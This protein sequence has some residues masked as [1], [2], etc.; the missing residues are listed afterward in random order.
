MR[1][2]LNLDE[3]TKLGINKCK[4]EFIKRNLAGD[5]VDMT[6]AFINNPTKNSF[7]N[8]CFEIACEAGHINTVK[9]MLQHPT[10]HNDIDNNNLYYAGKSGN[11]EIISMVMEACK[12]TYN[13]K[14]EVIR[15]EN[16]VILKEWEFIVKSWIT[17][18]KEWTKDTVELN[19]DPNELCTAQTIYNIVVSKY[20]MCVENIKHYKSIIKNC[21]YFPGSKEY[22]I[23]TG[24]IIHIRTTD[25]LKCKD[26]MRKYNKYYRT[27]LYYISSFEFEINAWTSCLQG[28]S[29]GGHTDMVKM[30]VA[31]FVNKN[32][33][34]NNTDNNTVNTDIWSNIT[35][36]ERCWNYACSSGNI[37]LVCYFMEQ[38]IRGQVRLNAGLSIASKLEHFEA[39]DLL[40]KNGA[41]LPKNSTVSCGEYNIDIKT[42][43]ID[44]KSVYCF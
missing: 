17:I 3:L 6:Q 25:Y 5:A 41:Y 11:Y 8:E 31:N 18:V 30:Y 23:Y 35:I 26:Y 16:N 12:R 33:N 20:N 28:L 19:L 10:L 34:A 2:M 32:C 4:T 13:V 7:L 22:E 39:V 40:I 42:E 9:K 24:Q 15:Q 36:W 38:G 29:R 43:Y 21:N 44:D 27:K 1:N 37:E 14:C